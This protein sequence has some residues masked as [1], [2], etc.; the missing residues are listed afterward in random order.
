MGIYNHDE[1]LTMIR[2]K[3]GGTTQRYS[4]AIWIL[5]ILSA[6]GQ[7]KQACSIITRYALLNAECEDRGFST[8][9]QDLP[10]DT[11]VLKMQENYLDSLQKDAFS[12][13]RSLQQLYLGMN[14]IESIAPDAFRH[15]AML[16]I[17]D[18]N[19]NK[20][21]DVPSKSFKHLS[22]SL[23]TLT[24]SGNQIRYIAANSL[25]M[26]TKIEKLDFENNW[27]ERIDPQAFYGL[28]HLEQ[29]NLVNND[30]QRLSADMQLGLPLG[31]RIL[32]L[33]RN[34]WICD[35]KLRWLRQWLTQS[36]VNWIFGSNSPKCAGPDIIQGLHWVNLESDRFACASE[37]IVNNSTSF[38][39][40]V[41]GNISI[42]CE[43]F[44]DPLPEVTWT[45]GVA[46][47]RGQVIDDS[48]NPKKYV[49]HQRTNAHK[50]WSKLTLLNA[51]HADAGDYK[52][53][54][55]NLAGKSEVTYKLWVEGSGV[56][57]PGGTPSGGAPPLGETTL[58]GGIGLI[59]IIA[60]AVAGSVVLLLVIVIIVCLLRRRDH[61]KHAYKVR[62]YKKPVKNHQAKKENGR[63][64]DD[65]HA[66][67]KANDRRPASAATKLLA[68]EKKEQEKELVKEFYKETEIPAVTGIP[69]P[70][71]IPAV[72]DTFCNDIHEKK[73]FKMRIFTS[74][75][76]DEDD[77]KRLSLEIDCPI[78]DH[79]PGKDTFHEAN[80]HC[81][82]IREVTP[83]L[84][85]TQTTHQVP[86]HRP[87]IETNHGSMG[88]E[89]AVENPYA[90]PSDLRPGA[91]PKKQSRSAENLLDSSS[92]H[93]ECDLGVSTLTRGLGT[94]R[95]PNLRHVHRH[96]TSPC[97]NPVCV[98]DGLGQT[99]GTDSPRQHIKTSQSMGGIHDEASDDAG[100][101]RLKSRGS[102]KCNKYA[103]LPSKPRHGI[104]HNGNSTRNTNYGVR[105]PDDVERSPSSSPSKSST[106]HTTGRL[107][108]ATTGQLTVHQVSP[109]RTPIPKYHPQIIR[110][111][112]ATSGV[113]PKLPPKSGSKVTS[114][115]G[116]SCSD[117]SVELSPKKS[118]QT[119][120]STS[121]DDILSPPFG[122]TSEKQ[123]IIK[124]KVPKP[125]EKDEYGTA[126]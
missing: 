93:C 26:L 60:G 80:V 92:V 67:I 31:L 90:K 24:L 86:N 13:Y 79:S 110:G 2:A 121:L 77:K 40:T 49:L 30:L 64:E 6:C 102:E 22:R 72:P 57:P 112:I 35:C 27:L 94:P 7:T 8:V 118:A 29:I 4:Y 5:F 125:G 17:L 88:H 28:E 89:R 71:P 109:T 126:V 120:T 100:R 61:R 23:R 104:L 52:C 11:K 123:K 84:L 74:H 39:L 41:G 68:K 69:R 36:K 59:I 19:T 65:E 50:L 1:L 3:S 105:F 56:F 12:N 83:D 34:Q 42:Q 95:S 32:R 51:M 33:H 91:L 20:L 81:N 53:I 21:D 38:Q 62:N 122:A 76:D 78:Q 63:I 87:A 117:R 58:Q 47:D 119:F 15:L 96:N 73:A 43:V 111:T 48:T 116:S 18:L 114:P 70:V 44:G 54:A 75:S 98:K 115:C 9:P 45:K 101:Q 46:T 37:I 106:Y 82:N 107:P 85:K 113:Y 25:Q 16:Q 103:T 55:K 10:K 14:Q 66:I 99:A 108:S 97:A 124:Q